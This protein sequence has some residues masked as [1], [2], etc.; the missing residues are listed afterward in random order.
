MKRFSGILIAATLAALAPPAS[1]EEVRA[2]QESDGDATK[3]F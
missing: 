3:G 1:L 2:L